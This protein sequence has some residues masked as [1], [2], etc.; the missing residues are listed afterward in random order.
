MAKALLGHREF[1]HRPTADGH[2]A[3]GWKEA[4]GTL[5]LLCTDG[6]PSLLGLGLGKA[7]VAFRSLSWISREIGMKD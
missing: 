4:L 5:Q 7:S 6:K 2:G 1:G 3:L